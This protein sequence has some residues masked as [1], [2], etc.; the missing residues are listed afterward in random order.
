MALSCD[1]K[2][3]SYELT[4]DYGDEKSAIFV[5]KDKL[6]EY[7]KKN[8]TYF[9]D[10]RDG[11]KYKAVKIGGKVWMGENLNYRTG[12]SWCL[13]ND[14][15]K[16]RQYGRL[17]DWNTAMSACPTGWHLPSGWEWE[18]LASGEEAGKALK[19]STGWNGANG[20]DVLGFAALPGGSLEAGVFY[21]GGYEGCWWTSGVHPFSDKVAFYRKMGTRYG[22]VPRSDADKNNGFSVRCIQ[23]ETAVEQQGTSTDNRTVT[24][25]AQQKGTFTDSR[26]G[27]TYKTVSIGG[28]M[29]MGENLNYQT[30]NSWCYENDESKCKQYGRLYDWNTA[31]SACPKGWHLPS[32]QEWNGMVVSAGG[33]DAGKA[34][35]SVAGWNKKG[36]GTDNFG[37]SALPGGIRYDGSFLAVGSGG[38]WWLATEFVNRVT[39]TDDAEY[40]SMDSDN[41]Y[42][43][44][45]TGDKSSGLSVRCVQGDAVSEQDVSKE[46]NTGGFYNGH[47][48]PD[49]KSNAADKPKPGNR[50]K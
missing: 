5:K 32:R 9:T 48:D 47:V 20:A 44:M 4:L 30:G 2:L 39:G 29:W 26:N 28:K 27:Q 31:K 7:K 50:R 38:A 18:N 19:S 41:N 33:G 6:E 8:T 25:T 24:T 22:N 35:K 16:C 40:R 13:G 49:V 46:N 1:Y 34:L 42:V 45:I 3:S 36:N 14:E 11:Q 37:F 15:S 17:Y 43:L 21:V 10:S 12:N 23:N